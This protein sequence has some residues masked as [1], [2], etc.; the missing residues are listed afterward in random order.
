MDFVD[1]SV[2]WAI[3]APGGSRPPALL[4]TD[5]GGA[6]WHAASAPA[7]PESVCF[8]NRV[9]GYLGAGGSVYS[10]TDGAR[11]WS[12]VLVAPSIGSPQAA[13]VYCAGRHGAWA[14]F[15]G[16]AVAAGNV[17]YI[18]YRSPDGGRWTPVLE[19]T[20]FRYPPAPEG[21][22]AYPG[23]LSVV[24]PEAAAFIGN[25]PAVGTGQAVP[26]IVTEGG[27]ELAQGHPVPSLT[28]A[29]SASF[30]TTSRG[31]VVGPVPTGGWAV[32]VTVD[33]G[34]SWVPQLRI[35]ART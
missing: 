30:P 16:R 5:D 13:H 20:Q 23:P 22:G 32:Y 2:G 8:S 11:T 7:V 18:V 29:V 26:V 1:P 17:A 10:T 34:S 24:D 28:G 27:S 31:W 3:T 6:R 33:G 21:P 25:N 14:L 12:R 4:G 9:E 35:G 15:T 19:Q